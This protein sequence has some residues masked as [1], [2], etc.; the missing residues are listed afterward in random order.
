M[1]VA[2]LAS[3]RSTCLRRQVGAVIV[4]NEQIISTGYNG[5][6]S[7]AIHCKILGCTRESL[8]VPSGKMQELCRGAH[9]EQNAI[10]LAAKKG[11]AVE[12][13]TIYVTNKPCSM[14]AKM[15]INS[16]I[17][18]VFFMHDYKDPFGDMLMREANI[19]I[20][21]INEGSVCKIELPVN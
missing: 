3:K 19:F 13:S 16:G 11:I 20:A 6:P 8:Q 14:C 7:G 12:G 2:I 17:R 18:E 15:I 9:A 21:K 4:K 10:A 5:A 1:S